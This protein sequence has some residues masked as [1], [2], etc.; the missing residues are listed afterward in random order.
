MSKKKYIIVAGI[1]AVLAIAAVCTYYFTKKDNI[2]EDAGQVA[3]VETEATSVPDVEEITPQPEPTPEVSPEPTATPTPRPT[4]T[5]RPTMPEHPKHLTYIVETENGYECSDLFR[6]TVSAIAVACGVSEEALLAY[7]EENIE[8]LYNKQD[9]TLI[10]LDLHEYAETLPSWKDHIR[11]ITATMYV[12]SPV[13]VRSG[14][15]V[16][17]DKLGSLSTNQ[18]VKVTGR[19]SETGWY[20]IDFNGITGYVSDEY[21]GL[22]K[23]PEPQ[24]EQQS[25][26]QPA[27]QPEQQPAGTSNSPYISDRYGY[28]VGAQMTIGYYTSV[29]YQ[30][31]DVWMAEN[32]NVYTVVKDNGNGYMEFAP[33]LFAKPG[34]QPMSERLGYQP[35]DTMLCHSLGYDFYRVYVGNDIWYDDFD[36]NTMLIASLLNGKLVFT[37]YTW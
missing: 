25:T 4:A 12:Q 6:D 19:C 29:T 8:E 7:V 14:P 22:E 21:L 37:T 2:T 13:N 34:E 20:E 35:G 1:L 9:D 16:D 15:S 18:E 5:P 27:Q 11:P 23:A 31:G 28:Q 36:P 17:F 10:R 32:G 26:Q 3:L 24:P 33:G 30:G